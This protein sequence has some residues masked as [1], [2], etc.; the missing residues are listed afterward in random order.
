MQSLMPY[1][2]LLSNAITFL[3]GLFVLRFL[4]ADRKVLTLF[5]GV[6]LA[7]DLLGMYLALNH[8]NNL[9][10]L[11]ILTILE[12]SFLIY[13]FSFWQKNPILKKILH[14]SI[15][16]FTVLGIAIMLLGEN[17]R[18]FNSVTRPIASLALVAAAGYALFELNKETYDSVFRQPRF[19]IGAAVML[20][21]SGTLVLFSL[22]NL[23]L[24]TSLQ[25]MKTVFNVN[26]IMNIVANA[27]YI[28]GFLCQVQRSGGR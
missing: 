28:G 11:H 23:L 2:S 8:I 9:W 19:W 24:G 16:L 18:Y 22:G 6:K 10:L 12:Y 15:P 4:G 20:Y 21:F 25:W 27:M 7:I 1:F 14:L 3:V 13:I 5:L 17:I 26:V